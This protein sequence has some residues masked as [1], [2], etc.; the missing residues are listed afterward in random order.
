MKVIVAGK[1][2]VNLNKSDFLA[3]GGE[4]QIYIKHGLAYKIY[5]DPYHKMIPTGKMQELGALTHPSI[6]KPEHVVANTKNKPIGFTMRFVKDAVALCQMFTKSFKNRMGVTPQ[7]TLELVQKLQELVVYAHAKDIL[8]VDLNEM[9]F[10][11]PQSLDNVLAI[12]VDS[13]QTKSFPATAIMENIRDR[14]VKGNHFTKGSDWFSFAVVAFNMFIGVHPYKGKHPDIK[15]WQDRMD[16]NIS[17][18]HPKVNLPK[19]CLPL[20]VIPDAYLHWFKAV[21]AD[22]QRVAP[23]QDLQAVI[24]IAMTI[25]K[26]TGSNTF[27][28]SEVLRAPDVIT[29]VIIGP[30]RAALTQ[31]KGVFINNKESPNIPGTAKIICLPVRHTVVAAYVENGKLKLTN[32]T[33]R[34][35]IPLDVDATSIMKY[36]GRFYVKS[37]DK[38][39]EVKFTEVGNNVIASIKMVAQVLEFGSKMFDG[40]MIQNL[41]GAKYAS[42][43]PRSDQHHQLHIKE[44]DSYN[45]VDA[46]HDRGVLIVIGTKKGK[47]D[48]FV[49]R[50]SS[51][52]VSYDSRL[53]PDISYAG[54]N[55]TVLDNGIVAH[56]TEEEKLQLFGKKLGSSNL[57]EINDTVLN[58]DMKLL[59]YGVQTMFIQ[60]DTVYSIV[61]R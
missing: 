18:F 36:D 34:S 35:I 16:Q 43:F 23:P 37:G 29:D 32:A 27:N 26:V 2:Q 46:K 9:N 28:I 24:D 51:D 3:S 12:D 33:S 25:K 56:L 54:I 50:L 61:M 21:L 5:A 42:F 1:G 30:I 55:F 59:S 11:L 22:G 4:G 49:I 15:A 57:K 17:V 13:W 45:I 58:G 52:Y 20:D 7:M 38:I 40:V 41:L 44:L 8:I 53:E 10:L 6:L 14:Q 39:L 48:K 60:D 31:N 47:Y 19:V